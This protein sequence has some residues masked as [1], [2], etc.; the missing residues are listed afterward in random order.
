M[1][2]TWCESC[3]DLYAVCAG[4]EP[5][6]HTGPAAAARR[7][8]G[9]APAW[10]ARQRH[11]PQGGLQVFISTNIPSPITIFIT[12]TLSKLLKGGFETIVI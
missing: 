1:F 2:C 7:P 12:L 3:G 6:P 5:N 11:Q 9:G 4:E 8:A 10:P